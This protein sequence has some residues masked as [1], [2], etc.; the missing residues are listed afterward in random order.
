MNPVALAR[1]SGSRAEAKRRGW[2]E[3]APG[4][5]AWEGWR[6]QRGHGGWSWWHVLPGY[7]RGKTDT[8]REA[9]AA[10]ARASA[11]ES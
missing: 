8:M 1:G 10:V 5:W 4:Y 9:L 11:E 2:L 3:A 7:P 6:I